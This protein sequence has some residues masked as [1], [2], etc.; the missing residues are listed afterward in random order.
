[1][2]VVIVNCLLIACANIR[3]DDFGV[4]VVIGIMFGHTTLAAG[5]VCGVW[6]RLSVRGV[7]APDE[8]Q[9]HISSLT[10]AFI[11]NTL[12]VVICYRKKE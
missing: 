1:M 5:S 11:G 9:F 7:R 4:E 3:L 6:F 10:F 12:P 2:P 8:I